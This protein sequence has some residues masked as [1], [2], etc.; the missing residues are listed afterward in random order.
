MGSEA[1]I[2]VDLQNDFCP[3]G[4]LAVAGRRRDRADHQ[5]AGARFRAC[6]PAP[7]TGTRRII[8]ALPPAIRAKSLRD[9]RGVLRPADAVARPLHPGHRTARPSIRTSCTTKAE[10]IIR[11][12]FRP[13]IDSYSAF[14]ENDH[15]TQTGLA[16]YLR[17]AASAPSRIA[18]LATDYCV[19]YSALDSVGPRASS[20]T[21]S[22]PCLPR[23]R[24]AV[25]RSPR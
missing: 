14:F 15:K 8:R 11:K 9:D 16:G 17:S 3:G 25:A 23:H 7:R 21:I 20:P 12:G 10:L 1:L 6:D 4:A 13:D 5:Q 19:A 2:V 22:A 18:G 24:P